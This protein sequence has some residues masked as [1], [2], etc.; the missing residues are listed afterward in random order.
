M[1][2][3]PVK[4]Y[5]YEIW[6][7]VGLWARGEWIEFCEIGVGLCLGSELVFVLHASNDIQRDDG[8]GATECRI[9]V[10]VVFI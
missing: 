2:G 4:S 5:V 6:E 9:D 3:I 10:I 1:N 7:I 8:M